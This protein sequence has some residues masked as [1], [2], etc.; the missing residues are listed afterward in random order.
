[1]FESDGVHQEL[2]RSE[3][4]R[5]RLSM[6]IRCF[7]NRFRRNFT[8]TPFL[9]G[10]SRVCPSKPLFKNA[11][12]A[13][14]S[15]NGVDPSTVLGCPSNFYLTAPHL[16]S[17]Y[18]PTN[19]NLYEHK[20]SCPPH[21]SLLNLSSFSFLPRQQDFFLTFLLEPR[22]SLAFCTTF[23]SS[24]VSTTLYIPLRRPHSSAPCS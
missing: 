19:R 16:F 18:P 24:C 12:A 11:S 5:H 6:K 23:L 3:P 22:L 8:V 4:S 10:S 7:A 17:T 2:S 1:M 14:T 20:F 9:R 15:I 21:T 13:F